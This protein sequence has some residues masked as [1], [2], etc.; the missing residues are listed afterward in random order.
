ML[1]MK[2]GSILPAKGTFG[3]RVEGDHGNHHKGENSARSL[4]GGTRAVG[5]RGM[6]FAFSGNF[7]HTDHVSFYDFFAYK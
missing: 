4:L 1:Q 6:S 7:S 2:A 3:A 5:D